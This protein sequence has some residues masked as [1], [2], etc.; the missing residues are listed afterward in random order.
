MV[1]YRSLVVL[2]LFSESFPPL[3]IGYVDF[4]LAFCFQG[5]LILWAHNERWSMFEKNAPLTFFLKKV[6]G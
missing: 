1:N 2:L 6:Q 5:S 4:S 3:G